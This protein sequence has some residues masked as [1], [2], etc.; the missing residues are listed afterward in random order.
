M[1]N[2]VA[3]LVLLVLVVAGAYS[4]YK[5]AN[6]NKKFSCSANFDCVAYSSSCREVCV[7]AEYQ[8]QNPESGGPACGVPW[9]DFQCAC[10]QNK[11]EVQFK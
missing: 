8:K 7:N 2:K 5:G 3:G 6:G 11:C 1:S 10:V 9:R 4:F